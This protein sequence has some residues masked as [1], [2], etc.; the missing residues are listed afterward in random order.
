M[1]S[2]KECASSYRA[3]L[4]CTHTDADHEGWSS[5]PQCTGVA[6]KKRLVTHSTMLEPTSWKVKIEAL[7][8]A[9]LVVASYL[10]PAFSI[11]H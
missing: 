3:P 7:V 9:V 4:Y 10:Y 2:H 11:W 6:E 1:T 5:I 8:I